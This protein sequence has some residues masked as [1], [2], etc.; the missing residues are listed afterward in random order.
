MK[1][2]VVATSRNRYPD[3]KSREG[4]GTKPLREELILKTIVRTIYLYKML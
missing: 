4:R 1:A 2:K 3:R